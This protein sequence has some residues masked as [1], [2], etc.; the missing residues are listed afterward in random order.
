MLL[1]IFCLFLGHWQC[2][3]EGWGSGALLVAREGRVPRL[4]LVPVVAII[5]VNALA[6]ITFDGAVG[7]PFDGD[8]LAV[9]VFET[10][11]KACCD[12]HRAVRDRTRDRVP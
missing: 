6:A 7:P 10:L 11:V 12:G 2:V 4:A 3:R 9:V 1:V 8:A 5:N